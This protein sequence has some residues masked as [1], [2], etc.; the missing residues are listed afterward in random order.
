MFFEFHIFPV[1]VFAM[2]PE[3]AA[4]FGNRRFEKNSRDRPTSGLKAAKPAS[5]THPGDSRRYFSKAK[6]SRGLGAYPSRYSISTCRMVFGMAKTMVPSKV[7][8]GSM[9]AE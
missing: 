4:W 8:P 7:S 6:K 9:S 3:P 2:F 1:H 5:R